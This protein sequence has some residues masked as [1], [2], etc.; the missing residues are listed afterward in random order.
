MT[1]VS[2]PARTR[3][4]AR[5]IAGATPAGR[6][7]GIDGLRALAIGGVVLGHW[8]IAVQ[9]P[10]AGG[11]LRNASP[12]RDLP[13]LAPVSWVLQTLAVFFLVGGYTAT[14]GRDRSRH[15]PYGEWLAARLRRL[16]RP[17]VAVTAA[18][19]AAL[20]VL[21]LAGVPAGT[22]RT[23][24]VLIVQPLWFIGVYLVATALTPLMLALDR[25]LGP[26]APLTSAAVVAAVDALRYG[27]WADAMP[28]WL[29]VM[30]IMP[31]WLF[32]YQLGVAWAR[33]RLRTSTAAYLAAAGVA[34]FAVLVGGLGYPAS[35]VGVPGAGRSNSSPPSLLVV[36]LAAVQC[37]L[38]V[39]L[40]ARLAAW[41]RRPLA[42]AV[43]VVANLTAMTVF[44]WHLTAVLLTS[45][46]T[47]ALAGPLPG[48]HITP[49]GPSWIIE[50]VLWLPA[51]AALL[52]GLVY[53][54]RRLE[55]P[56]PAG[57]HAAKTL[58]TC[59]ATGF[60]AYALTVL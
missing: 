56:W 8:L 51:F 25:P 12:L 15:R 54:A 1:R 45:L 16:G 23:C 42:W 31:G 17:V 3:R 39:P 44:C 59:A 11:A 4:W 20:A 21:A 26:A 40:R 36:A 53:A 6:D 22:L 55:S 19:G 47:Y 60:A 43:V 28:A 2:V 9:A 32:G 27:P 35:M 49:A 58:T 48:L 46:T 7:R 33:G 29:G 13:Y 52:A 24:A 57:H 18:W 5:R 30:N 14:L 50:R 38:A 10:D 41:L 37:G 34:L